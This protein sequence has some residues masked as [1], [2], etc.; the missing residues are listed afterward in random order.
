LDIAVAFAF[1]VVNTIAFGVAVAIAIVIA[2]T[3]SCYYH[4]YCLRCRRT[5]QTSR[6][7]RLGCR[8]W[9]PRRVAKEVN[10]EWW[11]IELSIFYTWT[12]HRVWLYAW[13]YQRLVLLIRDKQGVVKFLFTYEPCGLIRKTVEVVYEP[14]RFI[15]PVSFSFMSCKLGRLN[16]KKQWTKH[17]RAMCAR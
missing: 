1:G 15:G 7:A 17:L 3:V 4:W 9:Q 14:R 12:F 6:A 8:V 16:D 5:G 2:I 13:Q 11:R 10:D